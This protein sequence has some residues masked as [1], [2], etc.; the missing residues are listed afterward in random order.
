MMVKQENTTKKIYERC[1][2]N[3]NE[4]DT[5]DVKCCFIAQQN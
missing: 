4:N 2:L 1:L 5:Y 3:K